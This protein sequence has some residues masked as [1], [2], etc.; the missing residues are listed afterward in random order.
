MVECQLPKL[1]VAGS[2]PV[3][4]SKKLQGPSQ[5]LGPF[6][7][8]FFDKLSHVFLIVVRMKGRA[9]LDSLLNQSSLCL[10]CALSGI[11][12]FR[13]GRKNDCN[14]IVS[15]KGRSHLPSL[16]SARRTEMISS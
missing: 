9:F 11:M 5:E 7:F 13:V 3:S 2:N 6:S 12:P 4:R 16:E 10:P 8:W 1:K 15:E 14:A